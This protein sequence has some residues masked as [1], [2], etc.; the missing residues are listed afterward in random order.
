VTPRDR[1]GCIIHL[2]MNSRKIHPQVE[3]SMS[4]HS[5]DGAR[6]VVGYRLLVEGHISADWASW[7]G[8]VTVTADDGITTLE[9]AVTDQAELHGLLRRVHDLHLPLVALIRIAVPPT[10]ASD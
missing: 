4:G 5:E 2:Q 7:F 9:F 8:A 3:Q 6:E 1:R 10:G